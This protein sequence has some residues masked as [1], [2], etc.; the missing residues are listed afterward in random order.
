MGKLIND[1]TISTSTDKIWSILTDLELLD[2]TDPTV[3]KA[4]LI[5]E[6]K[7]GLNA[8]RKVLMQDGKNWFINLLTVRFRLK[9]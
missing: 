4:T 6:N 2:K 7:T 3:K 1:V 5:S 8:K 9:A